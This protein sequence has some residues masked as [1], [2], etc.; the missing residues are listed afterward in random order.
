MA[1]EATAMT[2]TPS[3]SAAQENW[4][5]PPLTPFLDLHLEGVPPVRVTL[6]EG[7]IR[8][9]SEAL[10]HADDESW[11]G[12]FDAG[13]MA[14][15]WME[16]EGEAPSMIELCIRFA[17]MMS[18]GTLLAAGM[19]SGLSL[20]IFASPLFGFAGFGAAAFGAALCAGGFVIGADGS[21]TP[22][23]CH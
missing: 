4:A 12:R 10:D 19:V 21:R 6:S 17:C 9:L 2:R 11:G 23:A 16:C 13:D 18:G 22:Y 1:P 20:G 14:F 8:A 15:E 7:E 3:A 5:R